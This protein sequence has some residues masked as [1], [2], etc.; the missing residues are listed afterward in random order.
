MS[1][2]KEDLTMKGKFRQFFYRRKV[3]KKSFFDNV[4]CNKPVRICIANW[5]TN[6]YAYKGIT[7]NSF[8]ELFC[9][10]DSI[11]FP[12]NIILKSKEALKLSDA[13]GNIYLFF[14][15]LRHNIDCYSITFENGLLIQTKTFQ[16]TNNNDIICI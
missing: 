4:N 9:Q 5:L 15:S 3:L 12:I 16:I 2:F 1:I 14:F 6:L 10:Y 13:K 8:S 7:I 11:V